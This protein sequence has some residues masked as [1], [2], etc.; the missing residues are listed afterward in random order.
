MLINS[1]NKLYTQFLSNNIST[2]VESNY[3][4]NTIFAKS[5]ESIK[6]ENSK[7][8]NDHNKEEGD[9]IIAVEEIGNI[10]PNNKEKSIQNNKRKSQNSI[11]INKKDIKNVNIKKQYIDY[12]I[13]NINNN[14]KLIENINYNNFEEKNNIII[15]KNKNNNENK[16]NKKANNNNMKDEDEDED[17]DDNETEERKKDRNRFD[18]EKFLSIIGF[19]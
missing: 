15:I 18:P 11:I 4:N 13:D 2:N 19:S 16:I 8:N 14:E 6:N 1:I 10:S 9:N 5:K 3:T 17:E 7:E 12:N